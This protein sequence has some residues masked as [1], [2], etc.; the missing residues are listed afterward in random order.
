MKRVDAVTIPGIT[1]ICYGRG[2]TCM[3]PQLP[4]KQSHLNCIINQNE[5]YSTC[6]SLESLVGN[7][8]QIQPP[9]PSTPSPCHA[10]G[11]SSGAARC[12]PAPIA[13]PP[14]PIARPPPSDPENWH[15]GITEDGRRGTGGV[16]GVIQMVDISSELELP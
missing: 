8:L 11:C 14:A 5:P 15:E 13:R 6:Q 12:S 1:R 10:S 4:S 9:S 7:P 16:G 3:L 2:W